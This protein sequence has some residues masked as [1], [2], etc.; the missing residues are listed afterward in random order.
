LVGGPVLKQSRTHVAPANQFLATDFVD[1]LKNAFGKMRNLDANAATP[2]TRPDLQSRISQPTRCGA[3]VMNPVLFFEKG[4]D[5]ITEDLPESLSGSGI[6][7]VW[8]KKPSARSM[9]SAPR[10]NR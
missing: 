3:R 4:T 2:E 9:T 7:G 1:Y 10:G 5:H 6:R 8:S